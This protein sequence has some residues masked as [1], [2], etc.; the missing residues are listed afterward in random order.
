M[1]NLLAHA[2]ALQKRIDSG[3]KAEMG[4]MSAFLFGNS[5]QRNATIFP[6]GSL[7]PKDAVQVLIIITDK[8]D[9]QRAQ[10]IAARKERLNG[11]ADIVQEKCPYCSFDVVEEYGELFVT[12]SLSACPN[13]HRSWCE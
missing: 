5:I 12:V 9:D 8:A 6:S 1:G 2:R 3:V 7:Q 10:W 13:C 4:A 11:E